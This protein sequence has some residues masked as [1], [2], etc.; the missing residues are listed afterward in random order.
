M[1]RPA[2]LVFIG[3]S[4]GALNLMRM[5]GNPRLAAIRAVDELQLISIGVCFG[6][7][8]VG[9]IILLRES[10]LRKRL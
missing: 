10:I 4:L 9:I 6:V 2:T 8:L 7:A 5:A 1:R 3:V